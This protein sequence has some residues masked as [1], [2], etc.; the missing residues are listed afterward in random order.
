M[1]SRLFAIGALLALHL[2]VSS[3]AA[4]PSPTAP[5]CVNKVRCCDKVKY[6]CDQPEKADC[7]K[8]GTSCCDMPVCCGTKPKPKTV[9]KVAKVKKTADCCAVKPKARK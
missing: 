8:T 3:V 1:F 7:C 9:V 4:K 6:C 2:T 5:C